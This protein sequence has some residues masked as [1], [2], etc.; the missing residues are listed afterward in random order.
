M[1]NAPESAFFILFCKNKLVLRYLFFFNFVAECE[2]QS[3]RARQN[4]LADTDIL[5]R[6]FEHFVV[7]EELDCLF[8]TELARSVETQRF[9]RARRTHIGDVFALANVDSYILVLGGHT[10]N[11]TFVNLRCL[12]YT[13]PSPR[14]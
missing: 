10:H 1:K 3:F 14:D 11:H 4:N 13:S 7:V 9:V 5:G 12:L 8:E 6:Y 2:F